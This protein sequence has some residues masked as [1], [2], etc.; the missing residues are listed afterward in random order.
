MT[1]LCRIRF[2]LSLLSA[3]HIR[4]NYHALRAISKKKQTILKGVHEIIQGIIIIDTREHQESVV[5]L[6]SLGDVI[7]R[8]IDLSL[9]ML[10]RESNLSLPLSR[11]LALFLGDGCLRCKRFSSRSLQTFVGKLFEKVNV[12]RYFE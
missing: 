6:L 11:L 8:Q 7:F 5:Q 2:A 3:Q 10:V 9:Q 4:S 1:F 12:V